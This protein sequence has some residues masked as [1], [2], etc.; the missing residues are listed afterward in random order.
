MVWT[1][2]CFDLLH[3]GHVY[4][5]E[6]ARALGDVLIVGINSDESI[7][8]L[9]GTTRPFVGLAGRSAVLRAMRAVDH[10]I[11]LREDT[12]CPEIAELR[13]DICVKD[14]TYAVLPLPERKIVESYGG[15][16]HLVPRLTGLSTT[17]IAERVRSG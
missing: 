5:L 3:A 12:P 6:T 4:L 8:R 13:P 17:D 1:N 10:V 7:R 2:G 15:R 16:M 9:K 14:D 11:T